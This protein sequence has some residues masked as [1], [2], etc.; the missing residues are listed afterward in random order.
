MFDLL[1]EESFYN[2]GKWYTDIMSYCKSQDNSFAIILVGIKNIKNKP[3]PNDSGVYSST[4]TSIEPSLI[5][6]FKLECSNINGYCEID[7]DNH[8][9]LKEPFKLLLEHFVFLNESRSRSSPAALSRRSTTPDLY[10]NFKNDKITGLANELVRKGSVYS[11]GASAFRVDSPYN[12]NLANNNN[13]SV[14]QILKDKN[15]KSD[16]KCCIIL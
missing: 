15:L 6:K 1:N 10:S 5:E 11:I 12:Y 7:F 14:D 16:K 2:L 9:S 4:F 8:R 13:E 3:D